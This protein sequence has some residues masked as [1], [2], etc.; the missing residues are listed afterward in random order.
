LGDLRPQPKFA[1]FFRKQILPFQNPAIRKMQI[2]VCQIKEILKD[3]D[4]PEDE[5]TTPWAV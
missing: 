5:A 4:Q 3:L 2:H 1:R